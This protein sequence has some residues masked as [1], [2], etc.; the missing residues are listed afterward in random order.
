MYIYVDSKGNLNHEI[1]GSLSQAELMGI[2]KYLDN[3]LVKVTAKT[4][5][6]GEK[7]ILETMKVIASAI[8]LLAEKLEEP[9][10]ESS[11]QEKG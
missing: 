2:T 7:N 3:L 11:C 10:K 6:E 4:M 5:L 1:I 9:P 8:S